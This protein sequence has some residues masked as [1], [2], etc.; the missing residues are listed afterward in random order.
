MDVFGDNLGVWELR[1]LVISIDTISGDRFTG[2]LLEPLY[3]T[4]NLRLL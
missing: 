2:W 4:S 1:P 3:D